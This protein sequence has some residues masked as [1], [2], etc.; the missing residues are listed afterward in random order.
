MLNYAGIFIIYAFIFLKIAI[1]RFKRWDMSIFYKKNAKIL[2][3]Y[4]V[5]GRLCSKM[6][7]FC[8]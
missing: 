3:F 7:K 1:K 6:P 5:K 8:K 4:M 2:Y